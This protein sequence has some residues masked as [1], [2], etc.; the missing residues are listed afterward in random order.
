[1]AYEITGFEFDIFLLHK[2]SFLNEGIRMLIKNT[3]LALGLVNMLHGDDLWFR[4]CPTIRWRSL[5]RVL[6]MTVMQELQGLSQSEGGTVREAERTR[7]GWPFRLGN[8]SDM[9]L[10]SV[11]KETW[12]S[13]PFP[14]R[15]DPKYTI[16]ILH[17][18]QIYQF[19]FQIDGFLSI[20][21]SVRL[22]RLWCRCLL[23][24]TFRA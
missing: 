5:K 8:S 9:S 21:L 14:T 3:R 17:R 18:L 10:R 22:M 4:A 24:T 6:T 16:T 11:N 7:V 2:H 20:I 13:A 19:H 15:I 1:M 12:W 23:L